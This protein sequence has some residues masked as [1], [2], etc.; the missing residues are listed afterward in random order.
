VD[1]LSPTVSGRL[2]MIRPAEEAQLPSIRVALNW[3][4][5]VRRLTA[6]R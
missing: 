5:E 6:A 1:G 4:D 3:F 2:L